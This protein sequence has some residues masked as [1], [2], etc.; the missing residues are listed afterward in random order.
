MSDA[1]PFDSLIEQLHAEGYGEAARRVDDLLHHTAWTT[2]TELRGELRLAL[3]DFRRAR[4]RLSPALRAQLRVCARLVA[5]PPSNWAWPWK[6]KGR[7]D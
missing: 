4:P 3:R 6:R 7:V 5:D 2:G 1:D